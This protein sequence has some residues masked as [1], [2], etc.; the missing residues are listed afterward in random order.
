MFCVLLLVLL[1]VL[2]EA[3]LLTVSCSM[4]TSLVHEVGFVCV[5]PIT[6]LCEIIK[7]I[8]FVCY[9]RIV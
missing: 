6:S 7:A 1:S 4:L 2:V 8:N 3:A 5:F 9:N